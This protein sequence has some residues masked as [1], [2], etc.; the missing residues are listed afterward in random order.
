MITFGLEIRYFFMKLYILRH[1][2]A[3]NA[4]E[5]VRDFDKK[6]AENGILQAVKIGDYLKE[7]EINQIICSSAVRTSE[8]EAIVN[9]FLKIDDVSYIDELYLASSEVIKN[10]ICNLA[11]EQNVL[12]IGHNFGIS[13]FVSEISGHDVNMSTC[14]LAEIDI[15]IDEWSLL[16]NETGILVNI[17]EPNQL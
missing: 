15:Q 7:I 3:E 17:T 5:G 4:I 11:I 12:F 9:E 2:Q 6:L 13:D 14:M 8:T 1:G 16:S 10:T